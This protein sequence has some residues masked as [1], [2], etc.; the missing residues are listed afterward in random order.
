MRRSSGL[1]VAAALL[2]LGSSGCG[3][4]SAEGQ[5]TADE[6]TP[7]PSADA[8]VSAEDYHPDRFAE[9]A[10]VD[11]RWYPLEPGTRA[12][13]RGSSIEAS[14]LITQANRPLG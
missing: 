8:W 12:D 1:P 4:P 5:K 9:S 13:Y 6:K 2:V 3:G 14:S 10:Q 11:H 7:A